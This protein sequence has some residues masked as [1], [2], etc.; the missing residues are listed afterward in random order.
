MGKEDLCRY[1]MLNSADRNHS[2]IVPIMMNS[3]KSELLQ[4]KSWVIK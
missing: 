3:T 4:T 1:L 2:D